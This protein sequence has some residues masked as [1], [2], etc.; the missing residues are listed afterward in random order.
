MAIDLIYNN[1]HLINDETNTNYSYLSDF[2]KENNCSYKS[3]IFKI[4]KDYL[5]VPI[6]IV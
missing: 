4:T 2:Y 6:K 5:E 1:D 3:F